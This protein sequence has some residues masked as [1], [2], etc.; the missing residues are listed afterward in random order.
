[1]KGISKV[2]DQ[3]LLDGHIK[4]EEND[5]EYLEN[6]EILKEIIDEE[7][8]DYSVQTTLQVTKN[9]KELLSF[10]RNYI[11]KYETELKKLKDIK[12]LCDETIKNYENAEEL[13]KNSLKETDKLDIKNLCIFHSKLSTIINIDEK[14]RVYKNELE[15]NL[16]PVSSDTLVDLVKK[17]KRLHEITLF[18]DEISERNTD[19]RKIRFLLNPDNLYNSIYNRAEQILKDVFKNKKS[20]EN[21]IVC[22][23]WIFICKNNVGSD[24]C[25]RVKYAKKKLSEL[26]VSAI[27]DLLDNKD[28]SNIFNVKQGV[29]E[30]LE[31]LVR[32]TS[33]LSNILPQ[34]EDRLYIDI[35]RLVRENAIDVVTRRV[36]KFFDKNN[37]SISPASLLEAVS[38]MNDFGKTLD[39]MNESS[40]E[41]NYENKLNKNV[42][43]YLKKFSEVL[44]NDLYRTLN[45]DIN[46]VFLPSTKLSKEEKLATKLP[47]VFIKRLEYSITLASKLSESTQAY[48]SD[49]ISYNCMQKCVSSLEN[50]IKKISDYEFENFDL[51]IAF[52]NDSSRGIRSISE[53]TD[54]YKLDSDD[55]A[56][57]MRKKWKKIQ[58]TSH[59]RLVDF[60]V[61]DSF[62]KEDIQEKFEVT[63]CR[64]RSLV[65]DN[66]SRLMYDQLFV[67]LQKS[68]VRKIAEVYINECSKPHDLSQADKESYRRRV[69][70][71]AKE[72]VDWMGTIYGKESEVFDQ[73]RKCL[74]TLYEAPSDENELKIMYSN[75]TD[76][77]QEYSLDDFFNMAEN[78]TNSFKISSS[79]K[80]DLKEKFKKSKSTE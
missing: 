43:K 7:N 74:A 39:T 78:I 46:S 27:E 64:M 4:I 52:I 10:Y 22:A 36:E 70:S 11:S 32:D 34:K 75:I 12:Q 79:I 18:V 26:F 55:I 65:D 31:K 45:N 61:Y 58:S 69:Y 80:S 57:E 51:L 8:I 3:H 66:I 28:E 6:R 60:L 24:E 53:F 23:L 42:S 41:R 33:F 20:D 29:I 62:G 71:D 40:T 21:T 16:I 56:K 49:N 25:E 2:E 72:I 5:D 47:E 63:F 13:K 37:D 77:F 38:I 1:M 15:N 76:V 35:T 73:Y 67:E 44:P 9:T 17:F 48:Y 50:L 19:S 30:S 68:L 14:I 54:I 59:K